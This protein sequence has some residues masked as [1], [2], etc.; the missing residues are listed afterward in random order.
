MKIET[1]SVLSSLKGK[2]FKDDNIVFSKRYGNIYAWRMNAFNG[3][4]NSAQQQIQNFFTEAQTKALADMA[5]PE[6][7]AE[8]EAIAQASDGKYK[9]ARGVAFASYMQ[10]LKNQASKG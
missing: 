10:E 6:K 5:D 3:P 9:T 2:L 4:F 1:I 7:R 8:W